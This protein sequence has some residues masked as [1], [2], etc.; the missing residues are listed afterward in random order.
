MSK[1][2]EWWRKF[3]RLFDGFEDAVSEALDDGVPGTSQMTNTNGHINIRG[4]FKSLKINNFIV[5]VPDR[6]MRRKP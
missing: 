6:V 1:W 5:R 2:R 4:D 3:D